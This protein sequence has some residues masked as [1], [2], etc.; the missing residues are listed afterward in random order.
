MKLKKLPWFSLGLIALAVGNA[1]ATQLLDNYSI[2][3][4]ITD[5]ESPIEIKNNTSTSNGEYLIT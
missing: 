1:Y 2:I 3:S 5:E 4:Y